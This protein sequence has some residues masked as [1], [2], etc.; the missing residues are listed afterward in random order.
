M[1]YRAPLDT[2]LRTKGYTLSKYSFIHSFI[3]LFIHLSFTHKE[4]NRKVGT[5]Y[6][7]WYRIDFKVTSEKPKYSK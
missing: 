5:E 6:R 2:S 1:K 3:H 7:L 4:R